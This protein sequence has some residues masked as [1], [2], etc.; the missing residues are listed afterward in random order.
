MNSSHKIC[1]KNYEYI[2]KNT[3][4]ESYFSEYTF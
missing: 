2:K 1:Y 3:W 4:I